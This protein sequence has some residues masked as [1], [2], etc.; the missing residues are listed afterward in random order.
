MANII[1]A[2]DVQWTTDTSRA[3]FVIDTGLS[4]LKNITFAGEVADIVRKHKNTG[5]L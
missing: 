2:R 5:R 1:L 4:N 3:S